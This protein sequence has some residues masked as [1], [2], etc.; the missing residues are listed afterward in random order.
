MSESILSKGPTCS[1]HSQTRARFRVQ[2]RYGDPFPAD[3][4]SIPSA[5]CQSRQFSSVLN[6]GS[7]PPSQ[8]CRGAVLQRAVF[9]LISHWKAATR[10]MILTIHVITRTL[11]LI[12]QRQTKRLCLNPC[13]YN[14]ILKALRRRLLELP[15]RSYL[16]T[17]NQA[18]STPLQYH[19]LSSYT[20]SSSILLVLPRRSSS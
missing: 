8:S 13:S 2:T 20:V 9:L 11:A 4:P 17:A 3:Q 1:K 7:T 6:H 14:Q 16:Y 5:F 19:L 12:G 18:Q 15:S 10:S